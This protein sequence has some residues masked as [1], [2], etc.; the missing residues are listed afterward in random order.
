MMRAVVRA[1]A[2]RATVMRPCAAAV[3][4][5]K[6]YSVRARRETTKRYEINRCDGTMTDEGWFVDL[7]LIPAGGG[8]ARRERREQR[9]R[10]RED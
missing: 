9:G 6:S 1:A 2:R 10:V 7:F 5:Q 8:S 3:S 4:Q